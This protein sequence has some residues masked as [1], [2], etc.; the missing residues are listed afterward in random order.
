MNVLSL[1]DD[2]GDCLFITQTSNSSDGDVNGGK[3]CNSSDF[4]SPCVS[5]VNQKESAMN[6]YS[7]ISDDDF[8][9]PSSQKWTADKR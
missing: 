7:D 5:L 8:E 3:L 9:I 4:I 2:D 6:N 1:E